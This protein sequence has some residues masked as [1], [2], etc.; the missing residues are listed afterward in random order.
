MLD[1]YVLFVGKERSLIYFLTHLYSSTFMLV[2]EYC[3]ELLRFLPW[4]SGESRSSCVNCSPPYW[5]SSEE[6]NRNTVSHCV[7]VSLMLKVK[8]SNGCFT[9]TPNQSGTP[10][11]PATGQ[12]AFLVQGQQLFK[13]VIS[14]RCHRL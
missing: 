1:L 5:P 10:K 8:K 4:S 13:P 12:D 14:C 9:I 11:N 2:W 3:L 7:Y 6:H